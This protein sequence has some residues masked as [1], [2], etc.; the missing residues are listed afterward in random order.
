MKVWPGTLKF[1]WNAASGGRANCFLVL[2]E[3]SY[4]FFRIHLLSVHHRRLARLTLVQVFRPILG[5]NFNL[6]GKI[7]RKR[8]LHMQYPLT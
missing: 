3:A 7:R 5:A 2:F 1:S 8:T 6:R 4:S